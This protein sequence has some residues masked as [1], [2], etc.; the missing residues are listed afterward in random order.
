MKTTWRLLI[1]RYASTAGYLLREIWYHVTYLYQ[2]FPN[3][4]LKKNPGDKVASCN[5]Y[6]ICESSDIK[7]IVN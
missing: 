4:L 6:S 5:H 3:D 2:T 1:L 7:E